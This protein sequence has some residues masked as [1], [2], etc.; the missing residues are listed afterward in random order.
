MCANGYTSLR[1]SADRDLIHLRGRWNPEG[2]LRPRLWTPGTRGSGP[3]SPRARGS[4]PPANSRPS[5]PGSQHWHGPHH[6]GQ[7]L[8]FHAC[9]DHRGGSERPGRKVPTLPCFPGTWPRASQWGSRARRSL[10]G[11]QQDGLIGEGLRGLHHTEGTLREADTGSSR[12]LSRKQAALRGLEPSRG[13]GMKQGAGPR[14]LEI[15]HGLGTEGEAVELGPPE[16]ACPAGSLLGRGHSTSRNLARRQPSL[17]RSRP[18][19]TGSPGLPTDTGGRGQTTSLQG[20]VWEKKPCAPRSPP[21][22]APRSL[23][24]GR[25]R[26]CPLS[27][28]WAH[29]PLRL[30]PAPGLEQLSPSKALC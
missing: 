7:A 8:V 2:W 6:R 5:A 3:P 21:L 18:S 20:A 22:S 23:L 14:G 13:A 28:C 25:V 16:T 24:P 11:S 27:Y 15:L 4:P 1:E 12:G 29:Y 19:S 17:R 26:A 10:N 30:S 9:W